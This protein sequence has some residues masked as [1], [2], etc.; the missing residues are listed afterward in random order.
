MIKVL[1]NAYA[2]S[3]NMGSEPGMAWNWCVNLAK[4]CE[5]HI[6]TEG[7]FRDIIEEVLPKLP[8]SV[9]M[10]FYY[11]PVSVEVRKMCWNQGDWRF[12][13]HYNK[14]QLKT[15]QIAQEIVNSNK[16]DILHQLNMIG[17]REPGYL[18]RIKGIP[19]IWGP[20]D[21]KQKFPVSYLVGAS[22]RTK[23]FTH[24]KNSITY[25]QLTYSKRIHL[26]AK[27]ASVVVSASTN[28]QVT[29]SKFFNIASPLINETGCYIQE[30][31][32]LD[33][34]NKKHLDLLWVGKLD[35]RKQL[36]IAIKTLATINKVDVVLHIVGGGDN[37]F[38]KNL[39]MSRGV[40]NRCKW[41]GLVS[42]KEVQ[43]M[44]QK[45]DLMFFTSVA[46]GTPHVVLEAIGNN[47]PVVCF[48]TC[49]QGDAVNE[50]VGVKIPLTNPKQS[51]VDFSKE[52]THLYEN[53]H[54]IRVMGLN[55]KERQVELSWDLK[56]KKMIE[57]YKTVYN[58]I[59][60][61]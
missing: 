57:L 5:L 60:V 54:L 29:F 30:H 47:L 18:W 15:Y 50:K 2:C 24:L 11:S 61:L 35:F 23:L 58:S 51:V 3:P 22:L 25:L 1:I 6:I 53:R 14:W 43:Q 27:S 36:S 46:E 39:A 44:M 10:Y 7:E 41:Y 26:A 42:H 19:F 16:I 48:N 8:Q 49:G 12:Y 32:V 45:F 13:K 56:V 20:V 37:V 59:D 21:A 9:N 17:F 40:E 31:E 55:C 52:I 33:K 34:T 4:Y 28:S 38:Y